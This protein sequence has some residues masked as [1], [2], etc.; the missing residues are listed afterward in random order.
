MAVRM[1]DAIITTEG[2]RITLGGHSERV[3][4]VEITVDGSRIMSGSLEKI[5]R[6]WDAIT[7]G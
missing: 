4:R 2:G 6:V 3:R 5:L 7:G 1:W